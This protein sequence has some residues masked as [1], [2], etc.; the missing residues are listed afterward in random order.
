ME[1]G[2]AYLGD[3][4]IEAVGKRL[5]E[6]R[7]GYDGAQVEVTCGQTAERAVQRSGTIGERQRHARTRRAVDRRC[8]ALHEEEARE[9]VGNVLYGG[10]ENLRAVAFGC[11]R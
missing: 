9:V 11:K 5:V 7:T 4:A 1:I 6:R 10:S 8:I 3:F 2:L